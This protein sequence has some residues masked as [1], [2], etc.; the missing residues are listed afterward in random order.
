MRAAFFAHS[1][2]CSE[3]ISPLT[4]ENHAMGSVVNLMA[5]GDKI[6]GRWDGVTQTT[7]KPDGSKASKVNGVTTWTGGTGKCQGIRGIV[8]G[9]ATSDLKTASSAFEGEYWIE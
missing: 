8:R 9:G 4:R 7:I 5:N 2:R 6:F 3:P 1:V